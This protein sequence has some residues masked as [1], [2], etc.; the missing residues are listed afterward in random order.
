MSYLVLDIE[1]APLDDAADYL[2]PV[3]APSNY[4]D[5]AKIAE[6][7]AKAQAEQ[8]AKAA[9]DVDLCRVVAIA[10]HD[11]HQIQVSLGETVGDD[12][13]SE[14][15]CLYDFWCAVQV[16][17]L[18]LV[19]FNILQ[20]DLPVLYRRSM[21]LGIEAPELERGKYRHGNVIDLADLLSE[22]GRLRLRSLDFYCRRFGIDIPPVGEGKDVP[23][24]VAAGQWDQVEEHV[25]ADVARTAA[26]AKRIGV[27]P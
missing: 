26:L 14:W 5:E 9:L 7:C 23:G 3:S 2:E 12:S 19:G 11:G 15:V 1:T 18:P 16:G 21:Y 13:R 4:K 25:R 10:W 8:L 22:Q 17:G 24:W 6:Y 20:F 27:L